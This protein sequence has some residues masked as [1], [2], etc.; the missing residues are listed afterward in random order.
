MNGRYAPKNERRCDNCPRP[1][2]W[3]SGDKGLCDEHLFASDGVD[4]PA[5]EDIALTWTDEPPTKEGWYWYRPST[6]RESGMRF[7]A[8]DLYVHWVA[9]GKWIPVAEF[10]GQWAG[11]IPEPKE[12][13]EP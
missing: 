12:R 6:S 1:A 3:V 2:T 8:D 10:S 7:V 9:A 4:D 11:P 13:S 5:T